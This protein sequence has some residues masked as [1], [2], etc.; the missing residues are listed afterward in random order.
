MGAITP[1][2]IKIAVTGGAGSGKTSVCSRLRERGLKIISSDSLAREVVATGTDAFKNIINYFGKKVLLPDG[3]L[4]RSKLRQ[5][6]CQDD[7]HYSH[8]YNRLNQ[9]H[10]LKGMSCIIS[11]MHKS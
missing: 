1:N 5:Y 7:G 8:S 10:P 11:I 6:G 9:R 3:T 4:N 2:I